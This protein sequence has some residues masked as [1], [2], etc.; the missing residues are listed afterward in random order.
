M[1][2]LRISSP[3]DTSESEGAAA[4]KRAALRLFAE[5]GV[6][7]TTV[8]EIAR[9]TGQRN[10]GAVGYYFGSKEALVRAIV[11]DGAKVIDERRNALLDKLEAEGRALTVNEVVDALIY[12]SLDV[13]G[14]GDED[15]YLRFTQILHLTYAELFD[16]AVGN[17]WNRG[18]QRCLAHLR[19]LMPAMPADLA[20]QRLVFIGV[21][22]AQILAQR[23]A[24]LA[25]KSRK[26]TI[27]PSERT[28]RHLSKTATALIMAPWPED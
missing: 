26:H 5:R 19:T 25:D 22:I 14:E 9:A 28:L 17:E 13:A 11:A 23:Q 7:G 21:Y 10:H 6:D 20:N 12:P 3:S 2:R 18:Y 16:S 1:A 8:R 24:V 15:C 27:W 4:I